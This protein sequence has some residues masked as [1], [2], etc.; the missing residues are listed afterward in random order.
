MYSPEE[1]QEIIKRRH[2][3]VVAYCNSK[4]WEGKLTMNQVMEIRNQ[5]DWKEVPQKVREKTN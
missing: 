2:A 4:G 1:S 5:Q 3:I